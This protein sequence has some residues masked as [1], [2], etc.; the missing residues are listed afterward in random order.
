MSKKILKYN[1]DAPSTLEAIGVTPDEVE[2]VFHKIESISEDLTE[3]GGERLSVI[4]E[5]FEKVALIDARI[6]RI[7][8]LFY[9]TRQM[10]G[11]EE[12]V[13]GWEVRNEH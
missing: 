1:H 3:K 10:P 8:M 11:G 2:A 7:M 5:E 13:G 12:I 4:I 9:M 6:F